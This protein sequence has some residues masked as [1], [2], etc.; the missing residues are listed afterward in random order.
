MF[1]TFNFSMP[2]IYKL[3]LFLFIVLLYLNFVALS[4]FLLVTVLLKLNCRSASI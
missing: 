3:S 4:V 1:Q 2:L